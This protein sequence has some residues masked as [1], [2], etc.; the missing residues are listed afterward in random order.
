MSI[1][2]GALPRVAHSLRTLFALLTIVTGLSLPLWAGNNQKD[3]VQVGGINIDTEGVLRNPTIDDVGLLIRIRLKRMEPVAA[4]ID[5]WTDMRMVSLKGLE[6]AVAEQHRKIAP[7]TDELRYLAGLQRIEYVFVYPELNDIVIAGPAEGWKVGER[8]DVI[9]KTTGRPVMLLDDLLVALRT[10]K[11]AADGGLTCSIDPTPEGL[12]RLQAFLSQGNAAANEATLTALQDSLGMQNITLRGMPPM[13]H[14]ARVMVA[15]DYRMKRFAMQFE[16][17]P[18][19]GMPSYLKMISGPSKNMMPRWWLTTNYDSL[20]KDPNGL[21]WQIRGPGV[22]AMTED[23]ILAANGSVQPSGKSSPAAQKW[24]D[25]MTAKYDELSAIVPIFGQLRNVMDMAVV[26]ALIEKEG[27]C[28][29]AGFE[30]PLLMNEREFGT[31]DFTTPRQVPSMASVVKKRGG[32]LISVSGG[33][34]ISS[35]QA[36]ENVE[37]STELA[38]VHTKSTRGPMAK[39]WWN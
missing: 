24:A 32:F 27:L 1:R 16:D 15:A 17:A 34:E 19:Q 29:K 10:A 33:V 2:K 30:M 9:G 18:V 26:G 39:W 21:A 13:T 31:D 14:F 35:W 38:E 20:L 4:D 6:A 12:T 8:G 7:L 25:T 28:E 3:F 11:A 22:K 5:S 37:E 23:N 36:I